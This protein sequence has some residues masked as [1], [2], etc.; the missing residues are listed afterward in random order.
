MDPR[1]FDA[2]T[3]TLAAFGTRRRLLSLLTALPLGGMLLTS[4]EE[5]AAAERPNQRLGRRSKRRNRKQRHK[6]R[7]NKNNQNNTNQN[8]NQPSG[9]GTS[10]PPPPPPPPGLGNPSPEA[11]A[12]IVDG[13]DP[14][15]QCSHCCQ[16]ACCL[17]PA[18]QCN[19][20]SGLC[21]A[22]NCANRE[23]GDDGCGRGGTC[24][25]GTG[26]ACTP[27]EVCPAGQECTCPSGQVCNPASG[28]CGAPPCLQ[29]CPVNESCT[30]GQCACAGFGES[31]A[32]NTC[33]PAR[34]SGGLDH[35]VCNIA[36][37]SPDFVLADTCVQVTSCPSGYTPCVGPTNDGCQACCPP[38][39][40]CNPAGFCVQETCCSP[41]T[42]TSRSA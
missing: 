17:P 29:R 40:T 15:G 38:G 22:P 11:C 12:G 18:N 33:C 9:G 39:T 21:C 25:C 14:T 6:R 5:E 3:K 24:G 16:E 36:G 19:V 8:T 26:G 35:D 4:D 7:R 42:T 2:L 31:V 37:V 28:Q 27:G 41:A 23:C 10:P 13:P 34:S 32:P 20:E 30:N 1:Q